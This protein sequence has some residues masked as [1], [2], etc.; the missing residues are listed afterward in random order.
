M[1][2]NK[3]KS[4]L[5]LWLQLQKAQRQ[6]ESALRDRLRAE[7]DSTLPRFEVLAALDRAEGGLRMSEL[8]AVLKVSNGNV[9]GIIERLV[10][11]QQVERLPVKGDRRAMRV[12]LTDKGKEKF[13]MMAHMHE[14]WVSDLLETFSSEKEE[15]LFMAFETLNKALDKRG[16]I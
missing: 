13:Q 1:T 9:T 12:K 4:R 2:Q 8:S 10:H 6:I 3:S 11:D 15:A 16:M 5:R 14:K 7:F